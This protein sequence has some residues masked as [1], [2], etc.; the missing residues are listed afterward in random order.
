M[1]VVAIQ[2]SPRHGGN[3]EIV[4]DAVLAGLAG[5]SKG[6]FTFTLIRAAEKKLS[7]CQECFTC[8]TVSDV[9]GCAVKDDMQEV[10][11]ALLNT[12]LIILASPV[13]C[14][15]LTA[16]IKAVLDRLYACFKLREIPPRWLLAGKRIALVL[17]AGGTQTEGANLCEAAYDQLVT[18][19]H[20]SD[21]GRLICPS[22]KGPR[23]TRSDTALLERAQAFGRS[24]A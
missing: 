15:G 16:Q 24:L 6:D 13:F 21:A 7:G 14:W 17:T 5:A 20:L 2:G 1:K 19:S 8:Q 3:T 10:Y 9:P 4:L 12:D 22:L 23:Q 11:T 18:M